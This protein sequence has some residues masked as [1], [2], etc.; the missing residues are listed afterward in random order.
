MKASWQL[1]TGLAT[2]SRLVLTVEDYKPNGMGVFTA[3]M[4]MYN[5]TTLFSWKWIWQVH[6][7]DVK[8][9]QNWII[10]LHIQKSW[11]WSKSMVLPSTTLNPR[12]ERAIF[13]SFVS[14]QSWVS[15]LHFLLNLCLDIKKANKKGFHL[16][17]NP[18]CTEYS[19]YIWRLHIL[20]IQV[21][22]CYYKIGGCFLFQYKGNFIIKTKRKEEE[23]KKSALQKNI[24]S[25]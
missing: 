4:H 12:N 13:F 23:E 11:G 10:L 17:H 20:K 2:V 15:F 14:S 24:I 7:C 21:S 19:K 1:P 6:H 5:L 3:F 16:S 18:Y 8:K 22:P 25:E 9:P